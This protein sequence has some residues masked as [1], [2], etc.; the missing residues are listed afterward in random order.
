MSEQTK[1]I[2]DPLMV[3][4]AAI[5]DDIQPLVKSLAKSKGLLGPNEVAEYLQPQIEELGLGEA[6][7]HF[8]EHGYAVIEDVASP[9]EMDELREAI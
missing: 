4:G 3:A 6:L 5:P 2:D 8:R 7:E 1:V 9:E